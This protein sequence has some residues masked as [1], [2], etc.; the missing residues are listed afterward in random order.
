MLFSISLQFEYFITVFF[1]PIWW[2]WYFC[3]AG[4]LLLLFAPNILGV[5]LLW[6]HILVPIFS[7]VESILGNN[8]SSSSSSSIKR[9][10]PS[11]QPQLPSPPPLPLLL[12]PA[13]AVVP[14][15]HVSLAPSSSQRSFPI[16][17]T[18]TPTALRRT[19]AT[20]SRED[21][22]PKN[23][24]RIRVSQKS[25]ALPQKKVLERE[26]P[27]EKEKP[28]ATHKRRKHEKEKDDDDDESINDADNVLFADES[29][30]ENDDDQK[31]KAEVR[32]GEED[33]QSNAG[34]EDE[35]D[36]EER[37]TSTKKD[38][39]SVTAASVATDE[40]EDAE[41]EEQQQR[42]AQLEVLRKL[43]K[44]RQSMTTTTSATGTAAISTLKVNPAMKAKR[45][46]KR[47]SVASQHM[48]VSR[49]R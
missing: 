29:Q 23:D 42:K 46:T 15:L 22:H 26:R 49:P 31:E 38:M 44:K 16:P 6:N 19:V 20:A 33:G 4:F 32:H 14:P 48:P 11:L 18:A 17:S 34:E 25:A 30:D 10:H 28:V 35:E 5:E 43:L 8:N 45:T 24:V 47:L 27:E 1:G 40:I 2:L 13:V 3:K 7:F 36:I 9:A 39:V 41:V 12:S 21:H 37:P